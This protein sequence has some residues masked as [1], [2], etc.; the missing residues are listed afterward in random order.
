[1]A[2]TEQTELPAVRVIEDP[3]CQ[4]MVGYEVEVYPREGYCRCWLDLA[5]QHLNRLGLMHGGLVTTLLDVACGNTA[6]TTFDPAGHA[7]LVTVSLNT[8][9]IAA[10]RGGRV[11]ATGT[12]TGGGRSMGYVNGELRD[13]QGQLL[14]TATA[15]FKRIRR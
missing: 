11:T 6:S 5:P 7:P 8:T 14:A 3:G 2:E 9:Y 15:V 10:A 4:Q 13:E 12:W 1:M